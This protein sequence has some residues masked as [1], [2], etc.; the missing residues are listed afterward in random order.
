[1]SN[2]LLDSEKKNENKLWTYNKFIH[3]LS[4]IGEATLLCQ[5]VWVVSILVHHAVSLQSARA[6]KENGG[7]LL[8]AILS[9]KVEQRGKL[10]I[11]LT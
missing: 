5:R 10:L 1:M 4:E 9:S 6:L 2:I 8:Q 7:E 11:T 3:E